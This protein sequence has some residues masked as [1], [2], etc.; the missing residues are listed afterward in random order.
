VIIKLSI[1]T[2]ISDIE[3][4]KEQV[5]LYPGKNPASKAGVVLKEY[6]TIPKKK[7]FLL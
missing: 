4:Y 5:D 1:D 2:G 7:T 3:S 6:T